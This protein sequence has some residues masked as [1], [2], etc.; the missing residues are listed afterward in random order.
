MKIAVSSKGPTLNDF[1]E[2]NFGLS[3]YFILVDPDTMACKPLPNPYIQPF[4]D[5][6]ESD[7]YCVPWYQALPSPAVC[8]KNNAV[9]V[10]LTG[11]CSKR[12]TQMCEKSGI[13]VI[14]GING[15]VEN[16]VLEYKNHK[17]KNTNASMIF[18]PFF[19]Q[20]REGEK[21]EHC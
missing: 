10:V 1:V 9:S 21:N 6:N 5:E 18:N 8:L 13:A 15:Q 17:L 12:N 19:N 4:S 16:A 7:E 14:S 3:P 2:P 11:K 20:N